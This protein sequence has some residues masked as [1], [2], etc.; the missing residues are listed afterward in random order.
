[1]QPHTGK[2]PRRRKSVPSLKRRE[3]SAS[4]QALVEG[5]AVSPYNDLH[6]RIANRAYE[7]YAARGAREG[8]ALDDWLEAEREILGPECHA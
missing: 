3:P 4:E 7:L 1:M 2:E 8:R 5:Q 6:V